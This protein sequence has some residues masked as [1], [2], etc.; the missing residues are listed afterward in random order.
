[1]LADS[2]NWCVD[3]YLCKVLGMIITCSAYWRCGYRFLQCIYVG[4]SADIIVLY[5]RYY[6][7]YWLVKLFHMKYILNGNIFRYD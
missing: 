5:I 7:K 4:M 6:S 3:A 2:V 1:M